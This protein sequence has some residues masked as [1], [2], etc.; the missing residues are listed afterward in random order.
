VVK[1]DIKTFICPSAA[2][3][4]CTNVVIGIV[5]WN[6]PDDQ[7]SISWWY[8]NYLLTGAP[9]VFIPQMPFGVTNYV[10][11]G[12]YGNN[13]QSPDYA[14]YAG[15]F[16]NHSKT[17]L[18][19]IKDGTSNTLLIGE[20]CGHR[21]TNNPLNGPPSTDNEYDLSWIG[22]GALYTRRGLSSAGINAEWRQF[23]SSHPG[24]VQFAWGDGS[25]RP[26]TTG[27]TMQIA[28][29]N[30]VPPPSSDWILLQQLAGY[31]DGDVITGDSL[32]Q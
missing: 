25:V 15:V 24:I 10:G 28:G 30:N 32:T 11:V 23:S 9:G 20:T 3:D 4:R 22:A 17:R 19:D 12:G 7:C 27:A 14:K 21:V 16:N 13:S 18:T 31:K 8:E 2:S 5:Y 26:M 1:N 6:R 29:P